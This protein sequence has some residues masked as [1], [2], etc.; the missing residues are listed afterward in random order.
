[1]YISENNLTQYKAKKI[2]N[3]LKEETGSVFIDVFEK[4]GYLSEDRM[5]RTLWF[6]PLVETYATSY[7]H[8]ILDMANQ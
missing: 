2:Y 5:K 8:R 7:R 3:E 6:G 1:L 4:I